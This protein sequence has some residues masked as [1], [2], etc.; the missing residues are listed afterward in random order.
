MTPTIDP[1]IQQWTDAERRG[2]A[3]DLA[4]LLADD[5]VGIGPVGFVLDREV[6]LSRFGHGLVYNNLTL[7]EVAEHRHGNTVVVVAHQH[8]DGHS[9]DVLLPPDTRVSFTI[10]DADRSPRIAEI[11]YSFIGPPL[12]APR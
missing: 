12:E 7:D 1:V 4:E 10:V 8:A 2:D 9:G 6:W 5:F 11:Q 3:G